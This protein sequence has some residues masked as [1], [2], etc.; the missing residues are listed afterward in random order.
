MS[1]SV[2]YVSRWVAINITVRAKSGR[3]FKL[4][5]VVLGFVARTSRLLIL[6]REV[7][8][9]CGYK[10]I[11]QQDR[12]A[13]G[14]DSE[15]DADERRLHEQPPDDVPKEDNDGNSSRATLEVPMNSLE[16]T[17]ALS[18]EIIT[19]DEYMRTPCLLYTSPSPRD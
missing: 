4:N 3:V 16:G 2:I 13:G 19:E 8:A 10:T 9:K 14:S 11:E 15:E 1:T 5:Q 12:D 7:C 18:I 17:D 6:G